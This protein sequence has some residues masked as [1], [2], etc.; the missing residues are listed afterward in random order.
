MF[1]LI[2]KH[3]I[4]QLDSKSHHSAHHCI[5]NLRFCYCW[6]QRPLVVKKPTYCAFKKHLIIINNLVALHTIVCGNQDSPFF[7]FQVQK[8]GIYLK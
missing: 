7:Q 2:H 4:H 5:I 6:K 8:K 1:A 3:Y